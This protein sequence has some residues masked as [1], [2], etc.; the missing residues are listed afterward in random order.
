MSRIDA[1]TCGITESDRGDYV[2]FGRGKGNGGRA[3]GVRWFRRNPDGVLLA[4]PEIGCLPTISKPPR[5]R[6]SEVKSPKIKAVGG[7]RDEYEEI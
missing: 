2:A 5:H 1:S 7:V 6:T 4:A 3:P